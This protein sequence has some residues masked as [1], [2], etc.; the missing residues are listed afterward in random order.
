M[1]VMSITQK[2]A[3]LKGQVQSSVTLH[4]PGLNWTCGWGSLRG[5]QSALS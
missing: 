4:N 3:A 1:M 5:R 2:S